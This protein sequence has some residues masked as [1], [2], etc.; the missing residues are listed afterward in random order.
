V[1]LRAALVSDWED[2]A[3]AL[4]RDLAAAQ[5]ELADAR[6]VIEI[7]RAATSCQTAE[8]A[9]GKI[10]GYASALQESEKDCDRL[11]ADLAASEKLC[12]E[13]AEALKQ[14]FYHLGG[15]IKRLSLNESAA[16]GTQA[17]SHNV[18]EVLDEYT[19][20]ASARKT[21]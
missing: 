17:L 11:R 6:L 3:T 14:C 7:W 4:Q 19:R 2:I 13:L 18:A 20:H 10:N 15:E 9:Q 1:T 8:C 5:A 21:K 16:L 12:D